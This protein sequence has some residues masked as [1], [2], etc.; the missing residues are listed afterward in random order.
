MCVQGVCREC[1]G[2]VQDLCTERMQGVYTVC[3][4]SVQGVRT[5]RVQGVYRACTASVQG[6]C[7]ERVQGI[8]RPCTVSVQGVYRASNGVS[9]ACTWQRINPSRDENCVYG[10]CAGRAHGNAP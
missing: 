9:R 5:E 3:A 6:V 2:C 7:K 8:Y 1:T 4:G 10:E